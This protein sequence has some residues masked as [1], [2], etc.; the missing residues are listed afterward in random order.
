LESALE[1]IGL[2]V[3]PLAELDKPKVAEAARNATITG[4]KRMMFKLVGISTHHA[5]PKA[6]LVIK[7]YQA[8]M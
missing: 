1:E 8:G 5:P 2:T 3:C 7:Q 6:C 4:D